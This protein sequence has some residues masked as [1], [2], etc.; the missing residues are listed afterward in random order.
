MEK[1]EARKWFIKN[2]KSFEDKLSKPCA[3]CMGESEHLH[4]IVPLIKGGTNNRS[5]I[6]QLCA[7]CH[8]E[9]H[10]VDFDKM[11]EGKKRAKATNP[12]YKEG[13][14]RKFDPKKVEEA[15]D[16]IELGHSF[17]EAAKVYGISKTTLIRRRDER[18]SKRQGVK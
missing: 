3:N 11:K 5:N 10:D 8:G 2:R 12:N 7:K 14:P 9:I 13:R 16:F 4:H 17:N 6:I 1:E 15:L 18:V